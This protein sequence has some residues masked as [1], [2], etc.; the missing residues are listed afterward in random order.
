VPEL[1]RRDEAV[2]LLHRLHSAQ[3][4]FH[5]GG[6][7]SALRELLTDDI[8]WHVPGRNAIAGHYRGID[9]E[10]VKLNETSGCLRGLW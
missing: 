9:S 2:A 4:L 5:G 7:D 6:D 10:S 1:M 3:N 8:A